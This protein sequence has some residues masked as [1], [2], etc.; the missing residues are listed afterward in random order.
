MRKPTLRK[1]VQDYVTH[2]MVGFLVNII[3][4]TAEVRFF[5]FIEERRVRNRIRVLT[6]TGIP[7]YAEG[8]RAAVPLRMISA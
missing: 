7:V 3:P 1:Q 4:L 2:G 5:Y 6:A 8:W